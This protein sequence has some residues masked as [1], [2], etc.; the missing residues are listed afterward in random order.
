MRHFTRGQVWID[1]TLGELRV[2][3]VR[4]KMSE[5]VFRKLNGD[6]IYL[7]ASAVSGR[8]ACGTL[9]RRR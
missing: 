3:Q 1:G 8:V 7:S 4:W 6:L 2:V 9:A 5:I